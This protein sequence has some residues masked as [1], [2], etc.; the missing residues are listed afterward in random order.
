MTQAQNLPAS[1]TDA[2][3]KD[4]KLEST[5][6]TVQDEPA[7]K[8]EGEQVLEQKEE[9]AEERRFTQEELDAQAAKIRNIERRKSEKRMEEERARLVN[10]SNYANA[11]QWGANN[12]QGQPQ[13]Q[14]A[15]NAADF[16][17]DPKLKTYVPKAINPEVL[18]KMHAD[19]DVVLEQQKP[20]LNE[21]AR[22]LKEVE[23]EI[24]DIKKRLGNYTIPDSALRAASRRDNGLKVL[25]R[26]E[27]EDPLAFEE[28][29][30][31]DS[32][33]Q[34]EKILELSILDKNK[35]RPPVKTSASRQP[36][37]LPDGA[38]VTTKAPHELTYEERKAMF[39]QQRAQ[40]RK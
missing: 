16:F 35:P 13:D 2:E 36:P 8:K 33:T 29:L 1:E 19:H 21:L 17:W 39:K 18:A 12:A 7:E 37:A 32:E 25:A 6:E 26:L 10:S 3:I 28:L 20:A 31:S 38:G 27:K 4:E 30:L 24:P 5:P 9:G 14:G 34:L 23:K 22:Q 11:N 15:N 40:Q